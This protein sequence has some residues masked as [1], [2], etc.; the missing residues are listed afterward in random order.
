MCRRQRLFDL[1]RAVA[2]DDVGT[3]RQQSFELAGTVHGADADRHARFVQ[4]VDQLMG[5]DESFERH[6]FDGLEAAAAVR[7]IRGAFMSIASA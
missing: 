6:A 3:H 1:S 7:S 4:R 5:E 2:D